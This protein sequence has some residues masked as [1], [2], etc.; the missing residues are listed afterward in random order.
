MKTKHA[1]SIVKS[2]KHLIQMSSKSILKKTLQ[3]ALDRD[4]VAVCD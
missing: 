2:L 3:G 4:A 1:N